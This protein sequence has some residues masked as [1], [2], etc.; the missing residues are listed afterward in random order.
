MIVASH[1]GP[2]TFARRG[3][4][5]TFEA[6]R[7]AGG[8][9]S[10]LG[11]LLAGR[12]DTCWIAAAITDDDRAAVAANAARAED[13]ELE[14]LSLDTSL[15]GMHYDV[16]SNSTLWFLMHGLFNL[17]YRPQFDDRF[18]EAWEAYVEVNRSFANAI[19]ETARPED[20]VLVQDIQLFLVPAMLRELRPDL[21]IT[22]FTH[23]PFCGPG[24]I[25][26]LPEYVATA[27]CTS[28]DQGAAGFHTER[29]ARAF[30]ASSQEVLG[31]PAGRDAF[32]ASFGPDKDVL[33][34]EVASAPVRAEI[35]A[36]SERVGERSLIVRSDRMELSKNIVRGFR[37][38]ELLLEQ[39]PRFRERVVFAAML[40][41][42]RESL[43]EY[44]AYR[45]EVEHTAARINDKFARG[46]WQPIVLDT[47]DHYARSIAAMAV[48][49]VLLVN[50][51]KD[52]LNLVAMEGPLANRRDG[53]VCLS[54]EAGAF[55]VLGDACVAVQPF[56]LT[57]TAEALRT[58]LDMA[59][60]ERASRARVLRQRAGAEPPGRWLE[61]QITRARP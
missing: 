53:V 60:D 19:A 16:V 40:N 28:L 7:G 57:Q 20:V 22:H 46:N 33:A 27:V 56:D 44:Q 4:D 45:N 47:R 58:G 1:R 23:T 54:R 25:R 39:H 52:G 12:E 30:R 2:V 17:P 50:P 8:V 13:F 32:V 26:V 38:Y 10:A 55:D 9:V 59:A 24:S 49:D 51:I 5:G 36:L 48:S 21:H 42:S 6:R 34:H 11:P 35:D 43:P 15:H 3:E 14:L 61:T 18:R 29:W 37:A 41:P 31:Q